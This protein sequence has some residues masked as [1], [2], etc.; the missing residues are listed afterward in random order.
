MVSLLF[1]TSD[2]TPRRTIWKSNAGPVVTRGT[3]R[4]QKNPL[5]LRHSGFLNTETTKTA[6]AEFLKRPQA[7]KSNRR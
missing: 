4:P 1:S 5:S 6:L 7:E 2:K 3:G